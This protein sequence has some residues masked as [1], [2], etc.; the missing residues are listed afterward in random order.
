MFGCKYKCLSC[1]E[2]FSESDVD[3]WINFDDEDDEEFADNPVC[4]Y[5]GSDNVVDR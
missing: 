3:E 5:C 4:P 1:G 2:E